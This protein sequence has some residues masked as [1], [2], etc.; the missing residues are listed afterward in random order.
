M[1]I[2]RIKLILLNYLGFKEAKS[3]SVFNFTCSN[4]RIFL[5]LVISTIYYPLPPKTLAKKKH[6]NA[7][8]IFFKQ[9]KVK[10]DTLLAFRWK[11]VTLL[12]GLK[13]LLFI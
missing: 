2:L 6:V 8:G 13:S 10:L 9:N 3:R 12:H 7:K 1:I 11:T 4:E 5:N